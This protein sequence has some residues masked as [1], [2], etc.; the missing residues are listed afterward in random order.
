MF[1]TVLEGKCHLIAGTIQLNGTDQ[2]QTASERTKWYFI[3]RWRTDKVPEGSA[4]SLVS[5]Q[6][7]EK[8]EYKLNPSVLR[9]ANS[10]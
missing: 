5:Q 2:D 10:P 8:L 9:M 1:L 6:C 4:M 7:Y 3:D